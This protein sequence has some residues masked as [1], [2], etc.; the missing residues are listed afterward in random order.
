MV[1]KQKYYVVWV[2][3]KPGVYTDWNKAKAQIL[4]FPDAKYKSFETVAAAET[5]F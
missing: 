2:G 3:A 1:K 5:A 4:G